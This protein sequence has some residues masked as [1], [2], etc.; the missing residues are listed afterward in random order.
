LLELNLVCL[1][2][3]EDSS[4]HEL[5]VDLV[6]EVVLEVEQQADALTLIEE[7]HSVLELR[8][9]HSLQVKEHVLED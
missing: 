6:A 8:R 9:A 2:N 3:I 7:L 5:H 4:G 1:E